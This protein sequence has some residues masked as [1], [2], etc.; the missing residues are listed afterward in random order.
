MAVAIARRAPVFELLAH[1]ARSPPPSSSLAEERRLRSLLVRPAARD[2]EAR[3][4]FTVVL[5]H[6][7]YPLP[8][9]DKPALSPAR[10]HTKT[11]ARTLGTRAAS[12]RAFCV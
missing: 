3:G 11:I 2:T 4:S 1:R 9:S 10:N 12:H 7:L 8:G 6:R 5:C